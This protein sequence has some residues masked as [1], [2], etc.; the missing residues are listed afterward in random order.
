[1]SDMTRKIAE[2]QGSTRR[3]R[4]ENRAAAQ[5]LVEEIGA[6]GPES[7][8]ETVARAVALIREL[9]ERTEKREPDYWLLRRPNDEISVH[10]TNEE[11]KDEGDAYCWI[12][13]LYLG[14][15][16]SENALAREL[17]ESRAE[18]AAA[19][20]DLDAVKAAMEAL[21]EQLQRERADVQPYLAAVSRALAEK[22]AE[23]DEW[24]R[25]GADALERWA[26][27]ACESLDL[28]GLRAGDELRERLMRNL[29]PPVAGPGLDVKVD[30][31]GQAVPVCPVCGKI[32]VR[33][34]GPDGEAHYCCECGDPGKP[35]WLTETEW[36]E[37]VA[38]LTACSAC[39]EPPR[40][41]VGGLI[42]HDCS[43]TYI[44]WRKEPR[45]WYARHGGAGEQA[46]DEAP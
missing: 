9:R 16:P 15:V 17:E 36:W 37:R 13:P 1:M 41:L 42:G 40:L 29:C 35:G 10:R 7:L 23:C 11:A 19:L 21:R 20:A 25:R 28:A 38:K 8:D 18:T 30:D 46:T 31:G 43:A 5:A 26:A 33:P 2:L 3:F 32:H 44:R 14:V 27:K 12:E 34:A 39:G 24:R 22:Q 45:E 6:V 4:N